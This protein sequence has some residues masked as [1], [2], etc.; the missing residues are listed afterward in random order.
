MVF[1]QKKS[2]RWI[3]PWSLAVLHNLT[4]GP[5][6]ARLGMGKSCIHSWPWGL[7]PTPTIYLLIHTAFPMSLTLTGRCSSIVIW[8]RMRKPIDHSLL[9]LSSFFLTLKEASFFSPQQGPVRFG[10]P[11]AFECLPIHMSS[12]FPRAQSNLRADFLPSHMSR[13]LLR[14]EFTALQLT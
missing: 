13:A 3:R 9:P 12:I 8:I 2:V 11:G 5:C 10:L 7:P 14:D 1:V 6:S 4:N